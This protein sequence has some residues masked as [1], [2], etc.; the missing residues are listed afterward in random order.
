MAE[1]T[2]STTATASAVWSLPVLPIK[3]T[4]LFP[5]LF[6]PLS[7]GRTNSVAAV[8]AALAGEEKTLVVVSQRDANAEQPAPEQLFSMGTRALI[9]KMVRT[10]QGI[11]ILVQ[12]MERVA[13]TQYEKTE[14]YLTAQVQIV[15]PP[16]DRGPEVEALFRAVVDLAKRVLELAQ[17][18]SQVDLGQL[19]NQSGDSLWFV[20][21]MASIM[22]WT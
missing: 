9:K 7:V 21:L 2:A 22:A 14:P 3:N 5:N 16:L 1:A 11:D 17:T 4:V 18:E 6:L 12:G 13:I 8:E 10:P 15:P 20:Y 19:V